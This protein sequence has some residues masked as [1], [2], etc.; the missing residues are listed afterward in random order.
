[1]LDRNGIHLQGVTHLIGWKE[2]TYQVKK[3][4]NFSDLPSI[5]LSLFKLD[6]VLLQPNSGR[7]PKISR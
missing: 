5:I 1:M 6:S 7:T 4:L 2:I 3:L